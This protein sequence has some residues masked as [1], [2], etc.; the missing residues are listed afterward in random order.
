MDLK[1]KYM[2]AA[3]TEAEKAWG[4]TTPN[5]M[6]GAV[7]VK[8]GEIIGRGY[9]HRAGCPH[10]ERELMAVCGDALRGADVYVTLEPCSTTGRT[11]PCTEGLISSGVKRVIVGTADPNPRHGGRGLEILRSAGIEVECGVLEKECLELNRAFFKW[12]TAKRPFVLL[13]MAMTLDGKIADS[14]GESKWI[15][16][17]A[18]RSRVQ[19]LRRWA[20]AVMITGGTLRRDKSRLTVREPADW[21]KKLHRIIATSHMNSDELRSYFPDDPDVRTACIGGRSDWEKVLNDL[22]SAGVTALLLEGGGELA[23][24]ALENGIV[25]AVEFHIAPKLLCGRSSIP[26][27][28]WLDRPLSSA[29][30]LKNVA[31]ES[32]GDDVIYRGDV[33]RG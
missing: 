30:K 13:K 20:D 33:D 1:E 10:A 5:P 24:S 28:G 8:D 14:T 25:D 23:G 11:P 7:A 15:T 32:L 22:G 2:A 31:V 26:V 3:L 29:L 4:L 12:I 6:V 18:A 16:G 21:P 17:S 27:T 9:H 19:Y